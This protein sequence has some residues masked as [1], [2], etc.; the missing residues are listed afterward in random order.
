HS[1]AFFILHLWERYFSACL[2]RKLVPNEN[3]KRMNFRY[4]L[5]FT[6]LLI[7][8]T[9]SI[10]AQ[11]EWTVQK[12]KDGIKISSRHSSSS[13]FNDIRVELDL[14]GNVEQLGAILVDV[15]K[16]KE[17]SYATKVSKLT[18]TLGPGHF[19]Y[20][21]EI[22]V[23]WPATN[24]YFYANF[25]LKRNPADRSMQVIAVN[26]PNYEPM[27]KDLVQVPLTRG[28]WNITTNT[29]KSIHVD[30]I[31]EMNPGGSLPVW[32]LNLFSTKGPLESFENL[33]QK[34]SDLNPR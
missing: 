2:K 22:E 10:F 9:V 16:Y 17:W 25:E 1:T 15:A 14:V 3:K 18:K 7:I 20:Y 28:T 19:I 27:P 23:P 31:L 5:T 12:V 21:N 30:Y 4:G 8:H 6:F 24:R 13:P 29:K 32:V 33:K 34:M 26:I 11:T